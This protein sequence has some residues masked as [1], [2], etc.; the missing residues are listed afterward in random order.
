MK[1]I[2]YRTNEFFERPEY[3]IFSE[4]ED[5]LQLDKEN[6]CLVVIGKVNL[7]EKIQ[8]HED[9]ALNKILDK[10]LDDEDVEMISKLKPLKEEDPNFI[11]ENHR[12]D[13][14]DLGA[15][16]ERVEELKEKY[17]INPDLGYKEALAALKAKK[18]DIDNYVNKITKEYQENEKKKIILQSEQENVQKHSSQ[19]S[20]VESS[21]KA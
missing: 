8:S 7:Q 3:P 16:Y 21:K 1:K 2:K 14:S 20:Q 18:V 6:D 4:E 5:E 9:N 15:E 10:Y 13:L 19:G 11:A 17:G 12:P